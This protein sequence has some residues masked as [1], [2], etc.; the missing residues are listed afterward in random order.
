M[1]KKVKHTSKSTSMKV[2]SDKKQRDFF[3]IVV[4]SVFAALTIFGANYI[5]KSRQEAVQARDRGIPVGEIDI[6]DPRQ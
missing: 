2:I 6:F 3:F 1:P 5:A 4:I